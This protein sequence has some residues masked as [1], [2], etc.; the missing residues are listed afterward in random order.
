ML[1]AH[2]GITTQ[3]TEFAC[4]ISKGMRLVSVDDLQG[5]KKDLLV[6]MDEFSSSNISILVYCFTKSTNWTEWLIVKEDVMHE[7]M[8]ILEENSLEFALPAMSIYQENKA[9]ESATS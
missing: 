6:Y 5:V 9:K 7:I 3:E 2:E 1:H 8:Y 4:D